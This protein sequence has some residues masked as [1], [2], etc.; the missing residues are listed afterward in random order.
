MAGGSGGI[1][2]QSKGSGLIDALAV[3]YWDSNTDNDYDDTNEGAHYY[4][5]GAKKRGRDSLLTRE[6]GLG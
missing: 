2:E 4:L 5:Q 6:R 3:R 1:A